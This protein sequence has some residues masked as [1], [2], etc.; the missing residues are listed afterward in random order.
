LPLPVCAVNFVVFANILSLQDL[1]SEMRTAASSGRHLLLV[2]EQVPRNSEIFCTFAQLRSYFSH[3]ALLAGP[4]DGSPAFS[5]ALKIHHPGTMD[6]SWLRLASSGSGLQLQ[7]LAHELYTDV[8]KR[9]LKDL[10]LLL[11]APG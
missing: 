1:E 3:A 9:L 2:C 4:E 8:G 6:T 10:Q 5:A 11:R 7:L